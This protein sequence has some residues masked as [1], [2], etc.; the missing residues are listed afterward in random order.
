MRWL[1]KPLDEGFVQ[2]CKGL[3][4][5]RLSGLLTDQVFFYMW[6]YAEQLKMLTTHFAGESDDEI[7]FRQ[8]NISHL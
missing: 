4:Q 1:K 6:M 8:Q 3:K 5:L 2:S 7:L